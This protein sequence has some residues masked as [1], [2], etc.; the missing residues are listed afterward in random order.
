MPVM[1]YFSAGEGSAGTD[2]ALPS[3]S[4]I[5]TLASSK[6]IYIKWTDPDD[7][8]VNGSVVTEWA[9]TVLVR[10]AG[11]YPTS[12]EDG[13]I[14]ATVTTRNQYQSTY[15]CDSG[16][17]NDTTY[18][19]KFF[20]YSTRNKYNDLADN[21]FAATPKL[22]NVG[23]VSNIN[24]SQN[25]NGKLAI[26][27][28]DPAATVTSDGIT[29]ATWESTKVVY[30]TDSYPTSPTDG[31]LVVNSTTRNAYSSTALNVSG[32]T[33]GTTYYF[34]FFPIT[35]DGAINT[36]TSQRA[37]AVPNR[38]VISTYPSQSGTLTYTGNALTPTWSGYDSSKMKISGTTSAT[39]AGTYTVT[40]TPLDDY[41]WSDGETSD[42]DVDWTIDKAAG[43]F[44][45][46]PSS[47]TLSNSMLSDVITVT[48]AGNGTVNAFASNSVVDVSVSGTSVIVSHV[49][50]TNGSSTVYINVSEG[51]NHTAAADKTVE[52]TANFPK[53]S[54]VP[55]QSNTL[56]YTGSYYSPTWDGYDENKL[57]ISG[58]TSAANAG[59]YTV[60]FTPIDDYSWSD[61]TVDG[62]TATWTIGRASITTVPSQN[63]TLTY[64]G[65]AQSPSWSNYSSSKLTIGGTTSSTNAGTY[66][67]TFTPTKNYQWSNG[68]TTAKSVSWTIAKAAGSLSLSATSVTLNSSITSAIVIVTRSGNGAITAK[69][70]NTSIAT[71]S[72][73]GT[74]VVV[75]SVNNTSGSATITVSVAEG[76]NHL[77]P[78][79]QT[80]EVT[81][82]FLPAKTTLNNTSW[83]DISTVAEAGQA[84]NYWSV[85]DC[86]AIA[87][88]GT[89][90]T[91]SLDK[92]YYVFILGFNHNGSSNTIDFGTFK[93]ISN[94][95]DLCLTDSIYS[96]SST[97][98]TL[99][100]NMNHTDPTGGGWAGSC[101][102]HDILG[103][104]TMWG[105]AVCDTTTA[106]NPV[107]NTLMAALPSDLRAV[108]RPMTIYTD[109]MGYASSKESVISE[110]KDYL[111]LLAEYEV[112]G[113]SL[114]GNPYDYLYQSQ[115]TYYVNGN[116]YLKYDTSGTYTKWW[117][118]TPSSGTLRQFACCNIYTTIAFTRAEQTYSYGVAPIFRVGGEKTVTFAIDGESYTAE[119]GMTWSDW[120]NSEYNVDGFTT[121]SST[122]QQ[123]GYSVCI[124]S[125]PVSLSD[126]IWGDWDYALE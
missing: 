111:P 11:S 26:K 81:A 37:T 87:I 120:V 53:V 9:G 82:E 12:H 49:D 85:G 46:S 3:V 96:S 30:K 73:S 119:V 70:N 61:G 80:F 21:E 57:S 121:T 118:R 51:T 15:F 107:A 93:T 22:V 76:T 126:G 105:S 110:S 84:A 90:G 7:L 74:D 77:A 17:T 39:N 69:S 4:G 40:F 62:K 25:G 34:S 47:L 6:K 106:T 5:A 92:N 36:S 89:V 117:T 29:L 122:V 23:T 98:G 8:V 125:T 19:Y 10:K 75:S 103:S 113:E 99:Y 24:I 16:L 59:T 67:A 115:Y 20:S 27:W 31:T 112:W 64:T 95:A 86:K 55:T 1:F 58:T 52:V 78:A 79:S 68:T 94:G 101:M 56:T 35:T 83:A 102:R 43:S 100:F 45:L 66:T 123:D 63:G 60:T 88:S 28:T 97:D 114:Q 41:M 18:Y 32:L 104:A 44:S 42:Y 13:T 71:V 72:V 91:L 38:H 124:D 2:F 33:N 14:V 108:M 54:A 109:N 116:S 48:R 65:S 50:R